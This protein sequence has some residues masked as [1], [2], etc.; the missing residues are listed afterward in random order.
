MIENDQD[1]RVD[2]HGNEERNEFASGGFGVGEESLAA[3]V[4]EPYPEE[5]CEPV[6]GYNRPDEF[7]TR[8][9]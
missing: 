2:G 4:H 6:E 9:L 1:D 7:N 8:N 3:Q 5:I